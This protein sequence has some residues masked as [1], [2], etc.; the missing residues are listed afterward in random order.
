MINRKR[1]DMLVVLAILLGIGVVITE[2]SYGS[3]FSSKQAATSPLIHTS[4]K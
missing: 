4:N 3:V 2:L 1:P